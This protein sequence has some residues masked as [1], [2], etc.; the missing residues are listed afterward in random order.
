DHTVT[1]MGARMLRR[2][3]EQPL[4]STEEIIRRQDSVAR[5]IDQTIARGDLRDALK[6]VSDI[7]RLVSRVASS[8][9]SPRDLVALRTSLSSLPELD[10]ALRKV[11]VGPLQ[12]LR[13]KLDLHE[14]LAR[15]LEA[16]LFDEVP[17]TIRDGGV[18]K[19]GFDTELD[20][21]RRL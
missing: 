15:H 5:L 20:S 4:L 11:S 3:V 8:L 16:A 6:K 18:F 9:A 7:E 10:D 13:N 2:W 1:P 17:H 14:D 12:A 21:L 19:E